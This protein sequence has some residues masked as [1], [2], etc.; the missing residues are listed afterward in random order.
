MLLNASSLDITF[1]AY[2]GSILEFL[3]Y[4]IAMDLQKCYNNERM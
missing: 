3:V 2:I 1:R 4:I